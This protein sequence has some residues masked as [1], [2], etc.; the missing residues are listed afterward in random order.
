MPLPH[1]KK[2]HHDAPHDT[3]GA[4]NGSGHHAVAA[5]GA[6]AVQGIF[7]DELIAAIGEFVGT[8][9]FVFFACGGTHAGKMLMTSVIN[10]GIA[11]FYRGEGEGPGAAYNTSNL[12]YIATSTALSYTIMLWM[13]FR[14]TPGLFNPA[15]SVG[16][17]VAGWLK[18]ARLLYLVPVQ[19]VASIAGAGLIAALTPGDF[20]ALTVIT[21]DIEYSRVTFLEV[22][23]TSLLML[24]VLFLATERRRSSHLAHI[25]IGIA[26]WVALLTVTY[27]TGGSLNPVRSFGPAVIMTSFP[28][29]H[30]CYWVGPMAGAF[31]AA[32]FY[33][34][35][36][37]IGYHNLAH[38]DHSGAHGADNNVSSRG[39]AGLFNPTEARDQACCDGGC[40]SYGNYH[41]RAGIGAGPEHTGLSHRSGDGAVH[42]NTRH[43]EFV[44]GR[45]GDEEKNVGVG[46]NT[47]GTDNALLLERLDRIESLLL[48]QPGGAYQRHSYTPGRPSNDGTLV[49]GEEGSQ[50]HEWKGSKSRT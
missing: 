33:R 29:Y 7:R 18:P 4:G 30:W 36:L 17:A 11:V 23:G 12:M 48:H 8:T 20:H 50:G 46:A 24:A 9:L 41:N 26:Y 1:F 35:L 14:I 13:F 2:T 49:E 6:H 28:G 39:K 15:I 3:G 42:D 31:F 10:P 44:G 27:W 34:F 45:R 38:P 43:G 47:G 16:L 37:L 21:A 19:M 25:G 40:S 22:F 32:T 5:H